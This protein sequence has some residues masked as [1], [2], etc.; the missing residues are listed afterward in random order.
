MCRQPQGPPGPRRHEAG[1]SLSEDA[2]GADGI[3]AEEL[4]DAKLPRDP[5]VTPREIGQRP[6]V[7]TMDTPCGDVALRAAGFR[8]RRR[9]QESDLGLRVVDVPGVQLERCGVGQG[10]RKR[11]SNLQ[12]F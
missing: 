7:I 3:A 12:G 5:V 10:I 1:Q 6:G 11:C 9:D 2:T 8:L 4:A